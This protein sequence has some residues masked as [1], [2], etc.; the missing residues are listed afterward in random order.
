LSRNRAYQI[1]KSIT[2]APITRTVRGIPVEVPL[3]E[4]DGMPTR[5]AVNL[6]DILTIPIGLIEDR[7]TALSADKITRVGEAIAFALDLR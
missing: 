6:D 7:I 4:S 5:C 2:V 1:R 3:D